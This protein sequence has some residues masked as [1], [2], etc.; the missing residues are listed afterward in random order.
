MSSLK[1]AEKGWKNTLS[2]I[3]TCWPLSF[4]VQSHSAIECQVQPQLGAKENSQ[5]ETKQTDNKKGATNEHK[6]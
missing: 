2:L 3:G 6:K 5:R 4:V 1:R